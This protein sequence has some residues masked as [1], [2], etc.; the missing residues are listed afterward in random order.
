MHQHYDALL[1]AIRHFGSQKALANAIGASDRSISNWLNREKRIPY[2]YAI[3]IFY[4]TGGNIS[5]NELSP[6]NFE[7]NCKIESQFYFFHDSSRKN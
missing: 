2:R 6:E 3:N 5:L 7:I 1:K 4:V